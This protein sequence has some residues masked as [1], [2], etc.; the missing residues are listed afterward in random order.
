MDECGDRRGAF[1]GIGQPDIQRNLGRLAGR[2]EEE[3]QAGGGDEAA[4]G[5]K[6]GGGVVHDGAEIER[7]DLPEDDEQG[8]CRKPKSPIRL[9]MNAFFPA[10]EADFFSNQKPIRRYEQS[11]TPSQPTN[12]RR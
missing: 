8:R 1:H 2:A 5:G 11:P 7:A 6:G 12:M 3:E 4:T 9:T 10:S